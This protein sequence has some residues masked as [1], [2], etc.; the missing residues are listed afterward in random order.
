MLFYSFIMLVKKKKKLRSTRMV[1]LDKCPQKRGFC[2][3]LFLQS[4]K[5]PNSALRKAA[6]I[7][8]YSKKK[9][10]STHSR[11]WAHLTEIF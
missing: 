7:M 10:S 9:I 2:L 1:K 3:K 11:C 5:K 4:P 8:L 6:R